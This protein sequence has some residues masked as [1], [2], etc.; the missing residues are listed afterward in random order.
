ML[1]VRC[2]A[3]LIAHGAAA[4]AAGISG[5]GAVSTFCCR[6]VI[7]A[8]EIDEVNILQ[9]AMKA[10]ECAAAGLGEGAADYVLVDGNRLP[11]ASPVKPDYFPLCN[12][13]RDRGR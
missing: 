12:V 10:M 4:A 5:R 2:W 13:G 9:A 3:K 1:P 11:K 8:G 6:Q 7:D